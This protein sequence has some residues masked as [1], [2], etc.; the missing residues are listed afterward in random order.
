MTDIIK[1]FVLVNGKGYY[2]NEKD[3]SV[4]DERVSLS[5]IVNLEVMRDDSLRI[6]AVLGRP[7]VS[8][9]WDHIIS[10]EAYVVNS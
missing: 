3:V 7:S 5:R 1:R 10:I 6:A 9:K 8:F 4:V 2:A